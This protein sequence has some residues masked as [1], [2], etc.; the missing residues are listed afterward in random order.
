MD[1]LPS[2]ELFL[3]RVNLQLEGCFTN[4]LDDLLGLGSQEKGGLHPVPCLHFSMRHSGSKTSFPTLVFPNHGANRRGAGRP[5]LAALQLPS[6]NVRPLSGRVT[7]MT[8]M[9]GAVIG[10]SRQAGS[11]ALAIYFKH[12]FYRN[13]GS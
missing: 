7:S 9:E 13:G 1:L 6:R 8:C 10:P 5:A 4:G 3:P 11:Q 12:G 2:P